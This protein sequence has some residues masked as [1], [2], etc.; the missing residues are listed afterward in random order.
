ML[1]LRAGDGRDAIRSSRI[2][3]PPPPGPGVWSS[4]GGA[5][6]GLRLPGMRPL[7]LA[8]A[9]Q[10][11]PDGPMPLSSKA[12]AS[13]STRS[14]ALGRADSV[15]RRADQTAQALFWT[16]HDLRQWNDGMLTLAADARLGLVETARLLALAHV[17]GGDA[18]IA[19][20][21]AKY[22]YWFW[23]PFQ[24]IPQADA[25]GNEKTDADAEW[26]PLRPTPAHPDTLPR[27]R[28][29]RPRSPRRSRRSSALGA[30]RSRST[31]ARP[32]PRTASTASARR[33]ATSTTRASWP[34]S[35][36]ATPTRSGSALGRRVARYVVRHRFRQLE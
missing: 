27:T 20:F 14:H 12:Y 26:Q 34:A 24:A 15:A 17:T 1:A 21:D 25:D 9:W 33:S 8:R 2:S 11:R 32:A 7:A 30:S 35:T 36:S 29:T 4:V 28:A 3:S 19:C 31:V 18:M 23:R 5:A 13:T 22:S 6:L 10:F 16:D